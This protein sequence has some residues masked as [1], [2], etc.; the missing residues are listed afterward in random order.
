[1]TDHS[2]DV[3]ARLAAWA[4]DHGHS[5][6]ELAIAWLA[7]TPHVASVIAGASGPDQVHANAAAA[8]W[9]LTPAEVAEVTEIAAR[10]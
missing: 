1:M 8:A 3:V 4:A 2:F 9:T 10:I 7:S 6:V 5:I